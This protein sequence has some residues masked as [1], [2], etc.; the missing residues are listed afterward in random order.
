MKRTLWKFTVMLMGMVLSV[1]NVIG[2][3]QVNTAERMMQDEDRL[4]V[5]GYAQIDYNQPVGGGTYNSGGLDVHRMVLMFGYKFNEKIQFVSEVEFEH[6]KEVFVEQAFLQYEILPWLKFR[7]GL[8]L[9]PMGIINEYHEPSTF[10]GVERPNLDSYIVPTT[11]REI[12]AGFSGVFPSVA[13]SYQIYLTNGFK[14]YDNGATLSGAN[15]FR[16][17]RQKGAESFMNAPNLAFKV[18]YFGIAGLQLGFSGYTGLTQS[19]LYNGIEKSDVSAVAMADSSVVGLTMF[20]A[21]ARYSL[22]GLQ[23]RAQL[24]YGWVSNTANYNEFTGSDMGSALSGWYG[25]VAYNVLAHSERFKSELL[26]FIRFEQYNTHSSVEEGM[27][28]DPLLKRTD[29]T[30]GLGWRMAKGAMLKL[31]YQ[32]FNNKGPGDPGHQVNA[33]VA[34]WF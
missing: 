14:S 19:S 1:A 6:V 31:D 12:G 17:G 34:V 33:G 25:E 4:T 18:N 11:W 21:D 27:T 24:N 10:N 7:G 16:K 28:P 2:Q 22:G 26:P 20:G 13:L 23:I 15:G 32:I 30:L 3:E 8:M 29:L 9:I 5:G